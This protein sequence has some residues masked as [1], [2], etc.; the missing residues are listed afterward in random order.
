MRVSII[1]FIFNVVLRWMAP[2]WFDDLPGWSEKWNN[3]YH[4]QSSL[5]LVLPSLSLFSSMAHKNMV[6]YTSLLSENT[7]E[8]F[9][10]CLMVLVLLVRVIR[11]NVSP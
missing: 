10:K 2:D 7:T 1:S 5:Q 8:S 3:S 11:Y 6:V 9:K 4:L